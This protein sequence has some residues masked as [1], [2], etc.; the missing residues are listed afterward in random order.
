MEEAQFCGGLMMQ[1]VYETTPVGSPLSAMMDLYHEH[2]REDLARHK[3]R[4]T[5]N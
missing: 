2:I 4:T 1:G 5:Q 3:V